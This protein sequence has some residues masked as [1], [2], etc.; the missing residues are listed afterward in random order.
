MLGDYF[1]ARFAC[2]ADGN[3]HDGSPIREGE[4]VEDPQRIAQSEKPNLPSCKIGEIPEW[5]EPWRRSNIR[6]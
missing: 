6:S 5:H 3:R 1:K 4:I 2:S